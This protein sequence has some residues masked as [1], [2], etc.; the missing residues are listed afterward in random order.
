MTQRVDRNGIRILD[1]PRIRV[2]KK[3]CLPT[4]HKWVGTGNTREVNGALDLVSEK[5]VQC[6]RCGD[7]D[8]ET[9]Q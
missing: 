2:E 6:V 7:V 4:E 1:T 9:D 8:W 3:R 5:E